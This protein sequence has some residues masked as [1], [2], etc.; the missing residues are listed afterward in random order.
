MSKK[1]IHKDRFFIEDDSFNS[2]DFFATEISEFD[3]GIKP[4]F[5]ADFAI[6]GSLQNGISYGYSLD[7]KED[8]DSALK[9][10][11]SIYSGLGKFIE[12]L[13]SVCNKLDEAKENEDKDNK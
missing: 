8:R 13:K 12:S 7:D 10:F 3:N 5:W 2:P 6:S 1:Y 11:E 9:T 4:K